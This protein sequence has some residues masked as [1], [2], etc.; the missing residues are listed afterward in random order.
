MLVRDGR[1]ATTLGLAARGRRSRQPARLSGISSAVLSVVMPA[2]N[3]AA[4]LE[5]AVREVHEGLRAGG[6][7]FELLVVENGFV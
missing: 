4:Y 7:D 6:L 2:H 5:T 1:G 3:E